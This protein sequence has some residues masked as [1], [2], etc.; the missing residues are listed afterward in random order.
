MAAQMG[1]RVIR[2]FF[3][4]AI[5]LGVFLEAGCVLGPQPG[6]GEDRIDPTSVNAACYVCHM[7]FVREPISKIHFKAKVTC[8]KC[9]GLSAGHAND[10]DVG[11]TKPDVI[12]ARNQIVPMCMKCHKHHDVPSA[13]VVA[14]FIERKLSPEVP[15]VCTDCHGKHRIEKPKEESGHE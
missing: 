2:L 12:F 14:R 4:V 13:A 8:I 1:A 11:A 10:E 6:E 5:T 9:H 7:T 15:P 3:C